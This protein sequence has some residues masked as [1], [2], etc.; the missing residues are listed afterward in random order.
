MASRVIMFILLASL[1][2]FGGCYDLEGGLI[3]TEDGMATAIIE[4]KADEY[5][6]GNEARILAWQIDFLF[7]EVNANYHRTIDTYEEDW[8]KYVIITWEMDKEVDL[9]LSEYFTFEG[10]DDGTYEFRADVPKILEEVQSDQRND[11]ALAFYVIL[12][13]DIDMAN[14]PHT[15]GPKARWV[16]SKEMLTT[17]TTLRAFTF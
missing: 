9:T 14:T 10:K 3:F 17:P 13:G 11:T 6:G 16:I 4:V 8:N 12:P 1:V 7:P 5:S 15:D 2:F